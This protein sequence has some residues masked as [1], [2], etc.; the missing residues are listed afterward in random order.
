[1]APTTYTWTGLT[2][3]DDGG[4]VE[5]TFT[6]EGPLYHGGGKRLREGA[7][8]TAGRRTN[9]WGDEGARSRYIHFTTRLETAAAYAERTGGHVYVVE[10]TG[11]F[12]MGYAGDEFKTVHPLTVVRRLER[13]EWQ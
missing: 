13:R 5:K 8:L 7:Q 10:P 9:G 3:G 12:A 4:Y 6:V 11:E 1:M 2:Y